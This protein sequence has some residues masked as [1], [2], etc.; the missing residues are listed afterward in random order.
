MW[1][2]HV[3]RYIVYCMTT[4]THALVSAQLQWWCDDGDI[5]SKSSNTH[6]NSSG[7]PQMSS[8]V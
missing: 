7:M 6:D 2:L 3:M 4:D 8:I 5:N 1:F